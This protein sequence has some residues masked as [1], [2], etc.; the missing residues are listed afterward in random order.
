MAMNQALEAAFNHLPIST[1]TVEGNCLAFAF[2]GDPPSVDN[3]RFRKQ[4]AGLGELLD[5]HLQ[6]RARTLLHDNHWVFRNGS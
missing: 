5:I 6:R 3:S 1:T 4:A 2:D